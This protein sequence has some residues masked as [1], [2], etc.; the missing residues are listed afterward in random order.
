MMVM[1]MVLLIMMTMI[2]IF[3]DDDGHGYYHSIM[4]MVMVMVLL[5]MMMMI[6]GVV[7]QVPVRHSRPSLRLHTLHLRN[8]IKDCFLFCSF[9]LV[10]S[11]IL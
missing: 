4:M 3:N 2:L 11:A 5:I 7:H 1:V 9:S 10:V 8:I 6:E